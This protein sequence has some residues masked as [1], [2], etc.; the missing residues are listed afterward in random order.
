MRFADPAVCPNCASLI[1]GPPTCLICGFD[2]N[3]QPARELWQTLL[4]A[5]ELLERARNESAHPAPATVPAGPLPHAPAVAGPVKTTRRSVSTGSILLGLGALF[6]LV[7]GFIFITVSWGSLG[8]TGRALVLLAFTA[9]VGTLANVVSRRGLRGSAEALWAVFLGLATVD[10]FAAWGEGLFGA[11]SLS[12]VSVAVAWSVVMFAVAA[13]VVRWAGPRLNDVRLVSPMTVAGLAPWVGGAAIGIHL[14]DKQDWSPFWSSVTATAFVV[15]FLVSAVRLKHRLTGILLAC[16]GGVGLTFLIVAAVIEAFD[17]PSVRELAV[18]WHGFPVL[19]IVLAALACG[20]VERRAAIAGSAVAML[21][22]TLLVALPIEDAHP[23]RGAF[24][25]L[26]AVIVLAALALRGADGW[27]RGARAATALLGAGLTIAALEWLETLGSLAQ[28]AW[29]A[30]EGT[31]SLW[32]RPT[33][34]DEGPGPWWLALIVLGAIAGLCYLSRWWPELTAVRGGLLNT[35]LLVLSIAAMVALA[36]AEV[37]FA[38]TALAMVVTGFALAELLPKNLP[39]WSLIGPVVVMLAPV[40][41]VSSHAAAL[42]VWLVASATLAV[43][44]VRSQWVWRRE[45]AAFASAGWGLGAAGIAMAL[46]DQPDRYIALALVL[47]AAAGLAVASL[48]LRAAIGRRGIEVATLMIAAVGIGF[49][50]DGQVSL[51]WLAAIW[52]VVGA[53]VSLISLFTPDRPYF[54]WLGFGALGVAYVLRLVASDVETVEAYTLPFGV[55]LLAA[56]LWW[57]HSQPGITTTRALGSG[58]LMALLPSLPLALDQPTSLR[59]LLLGV[60]AFL[61]L[62]VGVGKKWKAPFILGAAILLILVIANVGPMAVALP[63]WVL[64]ATVGTLLIGTGVTWEA[65]V[66]DGRAVASYLTSMR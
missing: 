26:S 19:V 58:L 38:V 30:G 64:I 7:A 18:G 57:M 43:I 37:P 13:Y 36:A 65:R 11:D 60:G 44:V 54:R 59:A 10:W 9:V 4:K 24:I 6:I 22:G 52:T 5:D 31:R 55:V 56:G 63:R 33:A 3:S 47:V 51:G 2:L 29:E 66:R 21:G 46:A 1:S 42:L 25:A 62:A 34:I 8:V 41:P 40:L 27:S 35:S 16:A 53:S 20:L 17:N 15:V 12:F 28:Q 48:T 23:D 39:G 14:F 45:L 32:A 49:A 61:A 50:C